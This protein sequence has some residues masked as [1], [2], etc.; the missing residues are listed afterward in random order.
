MDDGHIHGERHLGRLSAGH[1][2]R[3]QLHLLC[4]G[5]YK[6]HY[7]FHHHELDHSFDDVNNNQL[8]HNFDHCHYDYEHDLV[9]YDCSD[10]C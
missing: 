1:L 3:R 9:D 5:D 8:H 7:E 4:L 10:F 6:F 2:P